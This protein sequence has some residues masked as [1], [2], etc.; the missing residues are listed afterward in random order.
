MKNLIKPM[1]LI[2]KHRGVAA[3][4]LAIITATEAIATHLHHAAKLLECIGG[5]VWLPLLSI[6]FLFGVKSKTCDVRGK[7]PCHSPKTNQQMTVVS[8][9]P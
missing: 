4:L 6:G 1:Q 5:I 3:E 9:S 2:A 8:E 7:M